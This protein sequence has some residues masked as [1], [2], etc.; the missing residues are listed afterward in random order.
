MQTVNKFLLGFFVCAFIF[1]RGAPAAASLVLETY[2][3]YNNSAYDSLSDEN[4]IAPGKHA[5]LPGQTASTAHFTNYSKGLNGVSFDIIGMDDPAALSANDFI[6]QVGNTDDPS[7]WGLGPAPDSLTVAAGAGTAGSDRVYLTWDDN[8]IQDQW[9]QMTVL[10]NS[11]TGLF[12]H[13]FYYFGNL[14][15]DANEDGAVA[16]IDLS[17]IINELNTIAAGSGDHSRSIADPL[18][19][20]R[21]GVLTSGD[22]LIVNNIINQSELD[23]PSLTLFTAPFNPVLYSGE[24]ASAVPEPLSLFLFSAGLAGMF[25]RRNFL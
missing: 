19:I 16:P 11:V 20:T 24:G 6:F 5:L 12:A 22:V 17:L 23:R 7:G 13:N 9:L 2:M 18:D 3:F 21:D 8:A 4:A 10:S 1:L 15:G 25:V 14:I